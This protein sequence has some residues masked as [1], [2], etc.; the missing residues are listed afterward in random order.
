M[1]NW[2]WSER[3]LLDKGVHAWAVSHEDAVLHQD[4]LVERLGRV[5]SQ[6]TS[7]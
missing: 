3:Q 6:L 2:R 5:I 7:L 4:L 1:V